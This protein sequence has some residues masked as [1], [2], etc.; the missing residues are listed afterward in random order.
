MTVC[1][2]HSYVGTDRV[3]GKAAAAAEERKKRRYGASVRPVA[4]EAYGRV[5]PT[6]LVEMRKA[7]EECQL[8]GRTRLSPGKLLQR[9]RDDLEHT[10]MFLVADASLAAKG[11]T[12]HVAL[13]SRFPLG[14]VQRPCSKGGA[15]WRQPPAFA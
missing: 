3:P 13:G 4:I 12:A 7:A 14:A 6:S 2:P 11:A 15:E 10:L 1:T 8:Y 5:G 9:W